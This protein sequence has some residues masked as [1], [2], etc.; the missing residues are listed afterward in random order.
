[1]TD[2]PQEALPPDLI[3]LPAASKEFHVPKNTIR[4]WIKRRHMR[5]WRRG[6]TGPVFVRRADMERMAGIHEVIPPEPNVDK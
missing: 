2:E 5:K 3:W 4:T 6:E 1:M